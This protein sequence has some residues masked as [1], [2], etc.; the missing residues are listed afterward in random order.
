[1]AEGHEVADSKLVAPSLAKQIR[2]SQGGHQVVQAKLTTDEKV[3]ARVTDGIYREPASALRELVS[4]AYDADAS[5]VVIQTDRP[6]FSSI[7][8]SDDGNGMSPEVVAHLIEHIG[9]SAK[10][11]EDGAELKVTQSDNRFLSPGG[12]RLI[13]R[14]GIGLFS[15]SQLTHAFQIITK[16][17][18]DPWRTV[19]SVRL[20]TY[21]DETNDIADG[22]YEAGLVSIWRVEASD[23]ES[24]GTT[25]ILTDLQRHA[26]RTLSDQDRWVRVSHGE[27]PP[28]FNI[29]R[30]AAGSLVLDGAK[31]SVDN[32]PWGPQDTGLE[33]F[34]KLVDQVWAQLTGVKVR[35]PSTTHLF[36][37]YLQTVWDIA[38][39]APLP[40]IGVHPLMTG[41]EDAIRYKL[42]SDARK[43]PRD[44]R[45]KPEKVND[46]TLADTLGVP[47]NIGEGSQSFRVFIDNLELRRPLRFR[48]LPA[49]SH[50]LKMPSIFAGH[51][52]D[53]FEDLETA[54]SGGPLEF[55][56]Y[57]M[58]APKIAPTEH[59]G[60]LIRVHGASGT[61]FDRGFLQYKVA[62]IARLRQLSCEIFVTQGFES[63]L[64][65]DREGFNQS[66]PHARRVTAWLHSAIGRSINMQKSLANEVRRENRSAA[67][68]S[69][70]SKIQRVATAAWRANQP[71]GGLPPPVTWGRG[72][73]DIEV[74]AIRL[75]PEA[76]L[77]GA[78]RRSAAALA[79]Q[80]RLAAIAQILAAFDVLEYL[81]D[82]KA[83]ELMQALANVLR[84]DS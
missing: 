56:G 10:R 64:N 54:R 75:D 27:A 18:D 58:W 22:K 11:S 42:P 20:R 8:V 84:A 39:A 36:D 33:A 79:E 40:Y 74:D 67:A 35:N 7:T 69:T 46:G 38:L 47:S 59:N 49:T 1:M 57:L 71:D 43:G 48:S 15:V 21:D 12:R 63:A 19:A 28:A 23:V 70:E 24:S 51:V 5:E 83:Q 16:V 76:V 77:G 25:I 61:L 62:E 45:A 30:L 66:H 31:G 68:A 44:A 50:A 34:E 81:S 6:R 55:T 41:N 37:K 26:V 9:G 17:K 60:V 14:I 4:N 82:E 32:L 3:L 72:A 13:G 78:R 2:G 53:E 73:D 80:Q 65:I 29:G 52:R